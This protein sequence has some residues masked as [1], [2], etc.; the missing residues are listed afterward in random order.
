MKRPAS[1]IPAA[2]VLCGLFLLFAAELTEGLPQ[3]ESFVPGEILVRLK[4]GAR[5]DPILSSSPVALSVLEADGTA[6][7]GIARLKIRSGTT[8]QAAISAL[9]GQEGV[10]FAQPNYIYHTALVPNDPSYASQWG[11]GKIGAPAAWDLT[12]GS[13]DVLVAV[14]DTGIDT[15]HPDLA[16]TSGPIPEKSPATAWTTTATAS[17]TTSTG[18]IPPLRRAWLR[19]SRTTSATAPTSPASSEPWATT[20]WACPV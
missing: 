6:R 4:P 16:G 7:M 15:S 1:W 11:P 17:W 8:V 12:V 10:L 14:L 5:I 18:S 9:T 3:G 2:A 13:A 20:E 19:I